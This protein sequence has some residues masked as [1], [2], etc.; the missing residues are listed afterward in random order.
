MAEPG[1]SSGKVVGKLAHMIGPNSSS[2]THGQPRDKALRS[3]ENVGPQAEKRRVGT[4]S[5]IEKMT[6]LRL[7]LMTLPER[8]AL[9]ISFHPHNAAE[10][11]MT[12][13]SIDRLRHAGSRSIAAAVIRRAKIRPS[14][15]NFAWNL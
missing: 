12:C 9:T 6:L 15:H 3:V 4:L 1:R 2:S 14:L 13:R 7:S 5:A 11:E 8:F 10:S